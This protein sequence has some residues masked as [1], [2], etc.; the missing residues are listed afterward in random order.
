MIRKTIGCLVVIGCL[1]AISGIVWVG[2][3]LAQDDMEFIDNW[4][5]DSPRRSPAPFF[6]DEHNEAAGIDDCAVCHHVF[7]ADGTKSEF[8]SSEDQSCADCHELQD[9][10]ATPGLR[11]AYHKRCKG[12]HLDQRSGPI[13]CGQCHPK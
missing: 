3:G 4:A 8:D 6:H 10:D 2:G 9:V 1:V 12:C 5:F 13:V 7:E 11:K